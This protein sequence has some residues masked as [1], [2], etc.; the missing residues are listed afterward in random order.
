V[1]VILFTGK[2]GVG[3]TTV[4]AGTAV[5]AAA[6]GHRTL[7]L[8]TDAA[9]SLADAFGRPV[10]GD[11][12]ELA[13][14]L[15]V[16]QVDVQ[17]RFEKS[18]ADIQGYLL[19]VL[20]AAGVD[21]IT[22]EELTVLPGAEEILAL[23][24][25]RTQVLS[26]AWDVVI[27][28]C[29]PTAETLRLLALPEALGWYMDRVFPAERRIVK[30]FRPVLA[31]AAGVPMPA[32]PVFDAVERLHRD[33]EEVRSLLTGP[34]AGVR[35]VLTPETVVVAEARRSLTTL[36]LFGYRVDGV[37][38]NRVFPGAGADAWRREWVRAQRDVLVEVGQSF[39][40]LPVWRSVYHGSE[41]V[42]VDAL[43]RFATA[44][45]GEDDP[46]APQTAQSPMTLSRTRAGTV[47]GIA[48]P[49]VEK[50]DID[51][52]RHG[53][54]LVVTVGSYRRLIALPAVL[55][56]QAV[57]AARIHDGALRVLFGAEDAVQP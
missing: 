41:P 43:G 49:F 35:L 40:G 4:A 47:L 24:E 1:R 54:E 10:G 51:L 12:S 52:A 36:S 44:A 21:P 38:A 15:F 23:L 57:A 42:G 56:K 7:V 53:D 26:G 33:L 11:P 32:D 55:S 50:S 17:R 48:L 37:V 45:Y 22:A 28:D 34:Q 18:W 20:D 30:A 39:A 2:G 13:D 3:K 16:Q 25:V 6:E 9:H 5:R 19:T 29:A 31:K 14:R 27:V 46:V 8:S